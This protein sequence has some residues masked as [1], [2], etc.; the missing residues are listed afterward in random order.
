[1]KKRYMQLINK[2]LTKL[3]KNRY[4]FYL[5]KKRRSESTSNKINRVTLVSTDLDVLNQY[6]DYPHFFLD[7]KNCNQVKEKVQGYVLFLET[8]DYID[9]HGCDSLNDAIEKGY[10]LITFDHCEKNDPYF[11]PHFNIDLERSSGY[12]KNAFIVDIQKIDNFNNEYPSITELCYDLMLR[13]DE[14]NLNKEHV[15]NIVLNKTNKENDLSGCIDF[16]KQHYHRKKIEFNNITLKDGILYTYYKINKDSDGVSII[17]PNKDHIDDLK[18]CIASIEKNSMDYK[19][20]I[21]VVENNSVK[22]ETFKFYKD[23]SSKSHIHILYWKDEFNYSA[24]NNFAVK[25]SQ[26]DYLVFLNN[27]TEIITHDWLDQLV[28]PLKRQEVGAV[29]TKLYYYDDS[30]QHCGVILGISHMAA[31][32]YTGKPRD[33][34]GY[35]DRIICQ[36]NYSAVTAACMAM[37]K[38]IFNKVNGFNEALKVSFNDIDLCLKI[39]SI[40]KLIYYNPLVELYH[41]ESKSRGKDD[42]IKN[43]VRYDEEFKYMREHWGFIIDHDLNYNDNLTKNRFDCLISNNTDRSEN[44]AND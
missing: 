6:P 27:D 32:I 5:W 33:Y 22:E 43:K 24:I 3:L 28:G 2:I 13:C 17:I 8:G 39:L 29:G 18:R 34:K 30:I 16:L 23:I 14:L 12:I 15:E 40:G 1:M 25:Y 9:V 4:L 19:Y 36:Q 7:L 37:K 42:G 10:D 41:Y 31:H 21:I 35:M 20:E 26:F 38:E 11:K 44:Y